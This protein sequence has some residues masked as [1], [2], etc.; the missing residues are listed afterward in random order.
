L[1]GLRGVK[2]RV[3]E[4]AEQLELSR[5]LGRPSGGVW[6]GALSCGMFLAFLRDHLNKTFRNTQHVEETIGVPAIGLVPSLPH[7]KNAKPED[8]VLDRPRSEYSEAVR[9]I[10]VSLYARGAL[11]TGSVVMVTSAVPG[12]GKTPV[13][14]TLARMLAASGRRV[15]L[16]ECDL[17]CPRIGNVLGDNAPGDLSDLIVGKAEW[18]DVVQVDGRSGLHY[19]VGRP[20]CDHPQELLGSEKLASIIKFASLEYDCVILDTPPMAVVADAGV[21]TRS[22]T[23]CLFVVRWEQTPRAVVQRAIERLT[24]LGRDVTSVVLS[25]VDLKKLART[26]ASEEAYGMNEARRYYTR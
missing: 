8:Y 16:L 19:V 23:E 18:Q 5:F 1:Y 20:H 4:V 15:L 3:E 13:C 12:E 11:N 22:A 25:R 24:E 7:H 2:R 9:A 21:L 17:R 6:A 26:D 10:G 14:L